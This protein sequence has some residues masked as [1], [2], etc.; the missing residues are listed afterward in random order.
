MLEKIIVRII[1]NTSKVLGI[2]GLLAI[3]IPVFLSFLLV[4]SGDYYFV[5]QPFKIYDYYSDIMGGY[6]FIKVLIITILAIIVD[7]STEPFVK[8]KNLE[9]DNNKKN[10]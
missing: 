10:E 3:I 4:F 6:G 9:E 1:Y 8:G 5:K 2:I 7:E